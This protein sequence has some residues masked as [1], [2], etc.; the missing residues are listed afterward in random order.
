MMLATPVAAGIGQLGFTLEEAAEADRLDPDTGYYDF[1]G[2]AGGG[3]GGA[4]SE[5]LRSSIRTAGNILTSVFTPPAYQSVGP[6]GTTTIRYPNVPTTI[7][8]SGGAPIVPGTGI[9]N[10]TIMIIAA[11]I[12]GLMLMNRGR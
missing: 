3:G 9:T 12:V 2:G 10:T 6:G 8:G 11:A 5:I 1:G 4:G 7:P